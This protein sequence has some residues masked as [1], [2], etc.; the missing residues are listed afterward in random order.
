MYLALSKGLMQKKLFSHQ[1][2]IHVINYIPEDNIIHGFH[3]WYK[4]DIGRQ[5]IKKI[6]DQS[7]ND[8]SDSLGCKYLVKREIP[9]IIIFSFLSFLNDLISFSFFLVLTKLY[10][11]T[12]KLVENNSNFQACSILV[13]VRYKQWTHQKYLWKQNWQFYC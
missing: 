9:L 10:H 11:S 4:W 7:C 1:K 3:G 13:L 8:S 2:T 6:R 12:C 5:N